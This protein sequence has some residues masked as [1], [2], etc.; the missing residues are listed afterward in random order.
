MKES[1]I[2]QDNNIKSVLDEKYN[3]LLLQKKGIEKHIK[4]ENK[5]TRDLEVISNNINKFLE[6]DSQKSLF[7]DMERGI[8]ISKNER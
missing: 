7:E 8:E 6:L 2:K 5:N 1:G 3:L 4:Q